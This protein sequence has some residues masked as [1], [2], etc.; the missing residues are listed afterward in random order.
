MCGL[1]GYSCSYSFENLDR[2]NEALDHIKHRGP[3]GS[4][5]WLSNDNKVGLGHTRLSILDLSQNASQPMTFNDRY[6]IVYNGEIYNFPE[7]RD[8][9]AVLGYEF[10]TNG[11]TEVVL[12][13]F[14]H[15]ESESL[16]KLNGIF[17]LAIFDHVDETLTIARDV[18][19]VKPL[20]YIAEGENVFFSSELKSLVKLENK[21][22]KVNI[23]AICNY[24]SFLYNPDNTTINSQINKLKPGE[25]LK[26]KNGKILKR[27][28]LAAWG[29]DKTAKKHFPKE[30]YISGVRLHLKNA[31]ERQMVSDVEVGSF[32]SGGLDSSAVTYFA[33]KLNKNLQCF[34]ISS[35]SKSK[36]ELSEDL[37]Y[38]KSV[39]DYLGVNLNVIQVNAMD[40]AQ[41]ME[42]MVY[43]LDEPIADPSALNVQLISQ[44][45]RK[46]GIKVLLSGAGGDDVFSGYRR[47]QAMK[48]EKYWEWL[49]INWRTRL[50]RYIETDRRLDKYLRLKK[51]ANSIPL[52]PDLRLINYFR[53]TSEQNLKSILHK[54]YKDYAYRHISDNPLLTFLSAN[55]EYTDRLS[56]ML[57]MERRFFLSEQNLT[58]TDKMSM[59]AGVEVRVPFL[60]RDLLEFAATV[61]SKYKLRGFETKWVLKKAMEV[62]L[63]KDIIY[64][65]KTGFGLPLRQWLKDELKDFM[66]ELLSEETIKKRRIFDYNEVTKLIKDTEEEKVDAS[67]TIFSLM[68]IEIW[69]RK[70]PLS[71]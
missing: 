16:S 38:A 8:E 18:M 22:S 21:A 68:C 31:V 71:P 29:K 14:S 43:T 37:P 63:P 40:I 2:F 26:I 34:T 59:A 6:V 1:I 5:I 57:E 19:G 33:S 67:Y 12:K 17:S 25:V 58:Y 24:I 60:D 39:S 61:P 64:R 11:D 32:L 36:S 10:D 46:A 7:L 15:F 42:N 44:V 70:F 54:D 50:A 55:N 47:H 27:H 30:S 23:D 56:L 51:L 62:Y 45:A 48:S 13:L 28:F 69:L 4:G 41:S 9:L 65:P 53:W 35:L 20:Y 66:H 49:P 52:P 3:D